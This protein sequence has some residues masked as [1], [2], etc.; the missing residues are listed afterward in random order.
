MKEK[1]SSRSRKSGSGFFS[2]AKPRSQK[3]NRLPEI[4][5]YFE[6]WK[7]DISGNLF[8]ITLM[9]ISISHDNW[10]SERCSRISIV[11]ARHEH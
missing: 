7:L 3:A 8:A 4:R 6:N 11:I 1:Q 9:N 5:E 10:I 2:R